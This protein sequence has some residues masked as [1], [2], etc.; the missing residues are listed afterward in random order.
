MDN[1][2]SKVTINA[3]N[4][5][6]GTRFPKAILSVSREELDGVELTIKK[7][8][9]E[10]ETS[11]PDD[12]LGHLFAIAP[13]GTLDSPPVDGEKEVVRPS[14]NGWTPLFNGDGMVYRFDFDAGKA[15]LTN[16]IVKTPCYYADIATQQKA[17]YHKLRFK[18]MGYGRTSL[19]SSG[20]IALG[21]RNQL[22]TALVPFEFANDEQR[23]LISWDTGR[24]FEIDPQT[25]ELIAPVGWNEQW[26]SLIALPGATP[27][28]KQ[29]GS[30]AHPCF[31][32][33]QGGEMYTA[34]SGRS[35]LAVLWLSRSVFPRL[36]SI[37]QFFRTLSNNF[38]LR[39]LD[40]LLGFTVNLLQA[41]EKILE[42]S[43]HNFVY[44]LR[45]HGRE[46]GDV[47][48]WKL[49]QEDGKPIAI[50]QTLHQMG[51][52]QD[53]IILADTSF[54]FDIEEGFPYSAIPVIKDSEVLAFDELDFTELP[55][56]NIYVVRRADLNSQQKQI[57][58]KKIVIPLAMA[59]YLVDYENPQGRITIHAAHLCATDPA[60][61]IRSTDSS[62]FA[63]PE[64][65]TSLKQLAGVVCAP[66]DVSR[67]GC[68][69][70]DAVNGT[71]MSSSYDHDLQST[72]STAFYVY[73]DDRPTRKFEDIYW[74]SWGCWTDTLSKHIYNLYQNYQQRTVS[75]EEVQK[76]ACEGIPA[77]V[78][79][80]H[81]DRT[82]DFPKIELQNRYLFPTNILG[83]SAQF[84]P[85]ANSEGAREGYIVCVVISSD[86]L[87]SE[88]DK[89]PNWSQNSELWILD[90]ANLKEGPLYRIS[91]PQ[92]NLGFTLHTTWLASIP[93]TGSTRSYDIR[94]DYESII[95]ELLTESEKQKNSSNREVAE[96]IAELFEREIYPHYNSDRFVN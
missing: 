56:T 20:K 26:R 4:K 62:I 74:N 95:E 73:R 90:A 21:F 53:Y 8:L 5:Q 94:Q 81:I 38:L 15:K 88:S 92:L 63:D 78:C 12:L 86:S 7:G 82:D 32:P 57:T 10:E 42:N 3:E 59:H 24:P 52:T 96:K 75:L 6:Q 72:W 22:N 13:A 64:I 46:V 61:T 47:E 48:K 35:L 37:L 40:A 39:I 67:L 27:P 29:V 41:G 30:S 65:D 54:K 11:L 80:L 28:F 45:W 17:E 9:T 70:V 2:K 93:N 51:I 34:N 31:D 91:H 68:H 1:L 25:L 71:V 84:I 58:V 23:L 77:S 33:N 14:A 85:K 19:T 18:N 66:M 87:L 50:K 44:L 60:E 69:V 79:R 49:V 16:R 36:K 76:I 55:Q 43:R 89:D 83:T